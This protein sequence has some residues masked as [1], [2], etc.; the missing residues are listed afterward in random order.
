MRTVFFTL[1]IGLLP[2][3]S[4]AQPASDTTHMFSSSGFVI[5][6]DGGFMF[7]RG[8][9]RQTAGP[10]YKTL[11]VSLGLRSAS[12]V[13]IGVHV[14]DARLAKRTETT[15]LTSGLDVDLE[16]TTSLSR[17]ALFGQYG[18]R[19]GFL[20]PY[21]EV[22]LG[23]HDMRTV[24]KIPSDSNEDE[25]AETHKASA[26]PAVGLSVGLDISLQAIV[27]MPVALRVEGQ[28][29]Y[30]GRTDY[31]LFDDDRDEFVEQ[32]STT[33]TSSLNLGATYN[34]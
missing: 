18:P 19:V 32:T 15:N 25:N 33:T 34:F 22:L 26:A 10:R 13:M 24:T 6:V 16:T 31:L 5:G 4:A 7:T 2:V 21:G 12:G 27:R 17:V 8:R 30:G 23:L 3:P 9:F 20:R 11:Q 29:V 14:A 28:Y 1:L